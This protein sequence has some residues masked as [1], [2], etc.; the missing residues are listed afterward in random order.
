MKKQ[1]IIFLASLVLICTC[2]L[3]LYL[4]LRRKNHVQRDDRAEL[5]S[6]FKDDEFAS[7]DAKNQ[8]IKTFVPL[9]PNESVIGNISFDFDGDEADDQVVAVKKKDSG[10]I[11]LIVALYEKT[12]NSY[13]RS[14]EIYTEV[15][16]LKTFSYYPLDVTGDHRL[17][18]VYQGENEGQETVMRLYQ[19]KKVSGKIEIMNV[20]EFTSNG[21]IFI[22]Q[23]ERSEAYALL[24]ENGESFSIRVQG[25]ET[26]ADSGVN[27]FQTE[28]VWN[29]K[30]QKYVK[31]RKVLL[32]SKE[33]D[34]RAV[35]KLK[36][37]DKETFASLLNGL[38]RMEGKDEVYVYFDYAG[39]EIIFFQGG[40]TE[41]VYSWAESHTRFSSI[42]ITAVNTIIPSI[43]K[44]IDI[45]ILDVNEIKIYVRDNVRLLIKSAAELDGTYKKISFQSSFGVRGKKS[46]SDLLRE[47]LKSHEWQD[48]FGRTYRFTENEMIVK[49]DGTSKSAYFINDV[50]KNGVIDFRLPK[51]HF[52]PPYVVEIVDTKNNENA[53]ISVVFTPVESTLENISYKVEL[54]RVVLSVKKP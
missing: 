27:Q 4:I 16:K 32:E 49:K 17:S 36:K 29:K 40:D 8:L 38:W 35:K 2:V 26:N 44:N 22:E 48:N 5:T 54:P 28:Y 20:G 3:S 46:K 15:S 51:L 18:L 33:L 24:E 25:M 52:T 21:T 12:T 19:A 13:I 42:Y 9:F 37:T 39:K 43:K 50:G 41:S 30:L 7:K 31:G 47:I 1:S 53:T 14:A 10:D 11:F 23:K 6:A 45:R 34:A